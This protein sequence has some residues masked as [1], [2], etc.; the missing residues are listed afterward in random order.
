MKSAKL[1]SAVGFYCV[2]ES[3]AIVLLSCL[4]SDLSNG[5]RYFSLEAFLQ[6][7]LEIFRKKK[8]VFFLLLSYA[9]ILANLN[10]GMC[11]F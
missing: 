6:M 9:F 11:T 1:I 5:K 7:F 8:I 2:G 3:I 4:Q 10:D